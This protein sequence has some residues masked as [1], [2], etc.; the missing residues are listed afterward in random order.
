ML[1]RLSSIVINSKIAAFFV[2]NFCGGN[3][4]S[5]NKFLNRG[6]GKKKKKKN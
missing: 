1:T 2:Y 6:W 4:F 3:S 5:L